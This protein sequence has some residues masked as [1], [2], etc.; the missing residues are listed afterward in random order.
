MG[1]RV[2]GDE[3]VQL[4]TPAELVVDIVFRLDVTM[5]GREYESDLLSS[6]VTL[7]PEPRWH[8]NIL[9]SNMLAVA[10]IPMATQ[11]TVSSS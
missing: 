9:E 11:P 5:V 10:E 2:T 6:T 8:K 3:K 4:R 1:D 7:V